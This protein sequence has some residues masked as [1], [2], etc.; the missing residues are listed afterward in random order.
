M[1]K[2][3]NITLFIIYI[4]QIISLVILGLQLLN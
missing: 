2:K 3:I 1:I 4:I